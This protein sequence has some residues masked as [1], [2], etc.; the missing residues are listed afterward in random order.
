MYI[1]GPHDGTAFALQ[2]LPCL[3]FPFL[4]ILLGRTV[5]WLIF[6]DLFSSEVPSLTPLFSF[7]ISYRFG[8]FA[9]RVQKAHFVF[10]SL[11]LSYRHGA[12]TAGE[13][14]SLTDIVGPAQAGV[15]SNLHIYNKQ[16]L[17]H[18]TDGTTR[19]RYHA[20]VTD[21]DGQ[22]A[23][24]VPVQGPTRHTVSLQCSGDVKAIIFRTS[25]ASPLF[26][27][28][29]EVPSSDNANKETSQPQMKRAMPW[30]IAGSVIGGLLVAFA[31]AAAAFIFVQGRKYR[32][33]HA[34][35][36]EGVSTMEYTGTSRP[37][38]AGLKTLELVRTS[39]GTPPRPSLERDPMKRTKYREAIRLK[40]EEVGDFMPRRGRT[41]DSIDQQASL[42][43]N[44][45]PP[46][47]LLPPGPDISPRIA[48]FKSATV[49]PGSMSAEPV[50]PAPTTLFASPPAYSARS[51]PAAS[52]VSPDSS[53]SPVSP[54]PS[55]PI[56]PSESGSDTESSSSAPS[57]SKLVIPQNTDGSLPNPC[58]DHTS[59]L[60]LLTP[61]E[62]KP[63]PSP[64]AQSVATTLSSPARGYTRSVL[65]VRHPASLRFLHSTATGAE[66]VKHVPGAT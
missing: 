57:V 39:A 35:A 63:L 32:S 50:V 60:P 37:L 3:P 58:G 41:L 51:V 26:M 36:P 56:T 12:G 61:A 44:A 22:S 31:L 49:T 23:E 62:D 52:I 1:I 29:A 17:E 13:K 45:E 28:R 5:L 11:L 2:L 54:A 25:G 66:A 27:A 16:A 47:G 19:K 18:Q 53:A 46:A 38:M 24:V 65:R 7:A 20:V 64:Y 8:M 4:V 59:E 30:I 42:V 34:P 21:A 43:Q 40:R 48:A 14:Q 6:L 33:L 9:M 15:T 55:A 10:L